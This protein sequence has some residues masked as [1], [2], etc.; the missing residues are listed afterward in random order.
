MFNQPK[1]LFSQNAS[2]YAAFRPC[3]PKELYDFILSHVSQKETAWDCATG[4]GQVAKDLSPYFKKVFATD[5]SERQLDNATRL[6]NIE[7]VVAPSEITSFPDSTFDLITVGQA[8]HWFDIP[9]FYAEARRVAKPDA[10]LAVWGYGLLSITPSI[11]KLISHFYKET[12]GPYWDPMRKLIDDHYQSIPFPFSEIPS[13]KFNF[14]IEW[15]LAELQGYLT[16]WSSVQK[17]I[18][19]NGEDPV[20]PLIQ[21]IKLLCEG[22]QLTAT[23]PLFLRCGRIKK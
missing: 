7:Y 21:S 15:T 16:T 4:N 23:F 8:L 6:P 11:D 2:N 13:P 1:D 12:I 18:K 20:E 19:K 3:Y 10:V 14:S 9:A 5:F 17:F 22:D